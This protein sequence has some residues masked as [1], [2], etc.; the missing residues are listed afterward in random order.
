[1]AIRHGMR[2]GQTRAKNIGVN[3]GFKLH[4]AIADRLTLSRS[5]LNTRLPPGQFRSLDRLQLDNH[6]GTAS[7]GFQRCR[8]QL[9]TNQQNARIPQQFIR[10]AAGYSRVHNDS[11]ISTGVRQLPNI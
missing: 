7:G 11:V 3:P 6:A 4:D 5:G 9:Q 2:H 1:M 8:I 10:H